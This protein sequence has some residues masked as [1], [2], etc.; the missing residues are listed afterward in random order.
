MTLRALVLLAA[1]SA[2]FCAHADEPLLAVVGQTGNVVR[3]LPLGENKPEAIEVA[4]LPA[5]VAVGS[6]GRT[7]YVTHPDRGRVT[8]LDAVTKRTTASF[9]VKGQPFG[10]AAT[11]EFLYV[12]DWTRSLVLK[13]DVLTGATL[14][15][16]PTGKSPAAIVLSRDGRRAYV[17]ARESNAVSVIDLMAGAEISRIAVGKAPFALALSGDGAR[18]YVAN[19]Q[20]GDLSVIDVDGGQELKR[21]PIGKMPYGVAASKDG[22]RIVVTL[23]H[24]D[25]VAIVDAVSLEVTARVGVGSYPEG[26]AITPDGQYAAV[27]NWFEDTVS[28]IYLDA[29]RVTTTLRAAG[30]P[31]N[32]LALGQ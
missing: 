32:L 30:G 29:A 5:G 11:D 28:L 21:L 9:S 14:G 8:V 31:R 23:Q 19:V 20:S 25:A 22:G 18:L 4:E 24:D 10:A 27:A 6:D 2:P 26:V 17:A 12:T 16:I 1:L 15:E 13:I 3:L 7:L